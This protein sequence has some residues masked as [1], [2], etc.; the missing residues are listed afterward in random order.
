MGA[1]SDEVLRT[2]GQTRGWTK[3]HPIVSALVRNAKTP[4]AVSMTLLQ[5]LHERDM[6]G[7]SI[8]RNVPEPLRIAARKKVVGSDKR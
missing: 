5:R 2:I 7:L 4:L 8:D 6:R 1:V 3:S